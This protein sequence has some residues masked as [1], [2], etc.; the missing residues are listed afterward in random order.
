MGAVLCGKQT[1]M[2]VLAIIVTGRAGPSELRCVVKCLH[3]PPPPTSR[4]L[5]DWDRFFA[6]LDLMNTLVS[7]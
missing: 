7:V 2:V 5:A 3:E 1:H 4:C 6:S